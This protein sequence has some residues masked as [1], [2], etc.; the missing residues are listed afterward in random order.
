MECRFTLASL[1]ELL[2]Q[3][4]LRKRGRSAGDMRAEVEDPAV[5]REQFRHAVWTPR[6][7]GLVRRSVGAR[8]RRRMLAGTFGVLGLA[9]GWASPP[10]LAGES[11]IYI[12][13]R[14]GLATIRAD[15]VWEEGTRVC[16]R[17]R[18]WEDCLARDRVSFTVPKVGSLTGPPPA[19]AFT[20]D[21][22]AQTRPSPPAASGA[23]KAG[24]PAGPAPTPSVPRLPVRPSAPPQEGA[25]PWEE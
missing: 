20:S 19:S 13:L 18:G 21:A 10:V 2:R 16:Y 15:A 4:P 23:T 12:H 8:N 1:H 9:V 25:L 5:A 17:S 3:R 6:I 11:T 22:S 24:R 7:S 14:G